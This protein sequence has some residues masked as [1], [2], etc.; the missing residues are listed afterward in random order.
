MKWLGWA[1]I[2][3]LAVLPWAIGGRYVL[4]VATMIAIMASLALGLNLMLQIGQLSMAYGAFMGIG[5]YTSALLTMR[6]DMPPLLTIPAGGLMCAVFAAVLGPVFL[7]IKGV[8]FVLLTF[9]F[10]QIV[11]LVFQEWTD[12]FG[13]TGGLHGIPK[14][15]AFGY[16]LTEPAGIYGVAL[17]LAAG[18]FVLVRAILRSD[19][20]AVLRSLEA[21]EPLSRSLGASARS[22]RLAVFV[23]TAAM[24]G[25]AGGVYAHVMG[26]VSPAAFGFGLSVDLVVM[27]VIGGAASAWGPLLGALLIVP[28]PE[29]LR[30][31]K[32]YQ[33]LTYGIVLIV[34]LLFCR[35]G[36][37]GLATTL[38][39]RR[40]GAPA[41]D[42]AHGERARKTS[43]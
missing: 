17:A 15:S 22:W 16:R 27:N 11:N 34:F 30:G 10:G 13:G 18:S 21:D 31:A 42:G 5:A 19:I 35:D 32:E 9:A 26:F 39:R 2:A 1:A 14:L 4:H 23:L 33:L 29:L 12:V 41:P 20:G 36:L 38:A 8:Y 37:V 24:A 3:V 25:V 28:L 40:A 6:M 43:A 7:R